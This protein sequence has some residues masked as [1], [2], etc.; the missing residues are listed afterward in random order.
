[1]RY[2]IWQKLDLFIFYVTHTVYYY[3]VKQSNN[4][5]LEKK[6]ETMPAD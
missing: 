2:I 1:M 4:Y 5:H 3:V 6:M